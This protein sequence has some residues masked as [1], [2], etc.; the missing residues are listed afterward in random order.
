MPRL[1]QVRV[2]RHS[3]LLAIGCSL[4]ACQHVGERSASTI[5]VYDADDIDVTSGTVKGTKI[6]TLIDVE[7]RLRGLAKST[8]SRNAIVYLTHD[9][10][11]AEADSYR[12][13]INLIIDSKLKFNS[14]DVSDYLFTGVFVLIDRFDPSVVHLTYNEIKFSTDC[15]GLKELD[16]YPYFFVKSFEK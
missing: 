5:D 6:S 7:V 15:Q 14:P 16:Q 2:S 12:N 4:F 1:R 13:C 3:C 10:N 8:S 9:K 11:K